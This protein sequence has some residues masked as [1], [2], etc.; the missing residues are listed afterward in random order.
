M[1]TLLS[2]DPNGKCGEVR[3]ALGAVAPTAMRV[4]K[5]ERLLKGETPGKELFGRA[6][7]QASEEIKPI[8]DLRASEEYRRVLSR[9]LVERALS[10]AWDKLVNEA[11]CQSMKDV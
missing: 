5:A 9:V 4:H 6:A 3:I 11:G 1:A 7:E 8:S 10:K 2:L